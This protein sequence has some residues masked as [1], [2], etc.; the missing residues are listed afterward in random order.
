MAVVVRYPEEI[1]EVRAAVA[2]VLVTAV[3]RGADH[4]IGF[5]VAIAA[6]V[7]V[8]TGRRGSR[9]ENGRASCRERVE[10][11]VVAVSLKKKKKHIVNSVGDWVVEY[12]SMC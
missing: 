12:R 3:T 7:H 4:V 6:G 8:A 5:V 2:D 10:S 11:S 9:P 1:G